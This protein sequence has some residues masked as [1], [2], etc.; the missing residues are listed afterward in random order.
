M[1][2]WF[3]PIHLIHPIGQKS[4][5]F[6]KKTSVLKVEIDIIYI[7]KPVQITTALV[8]GVTFSSVF[9]FLNCLPALRVLHPEPHTVKTDYIVL[10]YLSNLGIYL[11][12]LINHLHHFSSNLI[13][14]K[15]K[16]IIFVY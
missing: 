14:M 3:C 16:A 11:K 4:I 10:K 1:L 13:C 12:T 7:L 6:E 5:H 8:K 9:H 2:G 15:I